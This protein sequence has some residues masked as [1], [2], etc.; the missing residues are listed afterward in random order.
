MTWASLAGLILLGVASWLAGFLLGYWHA[1]AEA[2]GLTRKRAG[3][4]A[5][6]GGP[7]T[8]RDDGWTVEPW[9]PN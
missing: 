7:L 8:W 1:K 2:A 6:H 5:K 3:A 9:P 4:T